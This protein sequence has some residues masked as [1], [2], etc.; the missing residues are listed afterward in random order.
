MNIIS[1][2]QPHEFGPDFYLDQGVWKVN[3]PTTETPPP[4]ISNDARNIIQNA[5]DG[6]Y[7]E[8][9]KDILETMKEMGYAN[10]NLVVGIGGL[11]VQQHNRDDLGFA[12][13]ATQAIINNETVE[14][15]KDPITDQ[16]KRSHKG[17]MKL[18]QNDDGSFTTIDQ[19]SEQEEKEGV[20]ETVFL[21]GKVVKEFTLN[22]I[23]NRAG[24]F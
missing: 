2:I 7:F 13:K 6:M 20:L 1:L 8:R 11:L 15:F 22:E 21:N 17:L 24:T 18:V 10:T 3:F 12:F 4:P 14:L 16:G 19:A 9:Y 23:R 5:G